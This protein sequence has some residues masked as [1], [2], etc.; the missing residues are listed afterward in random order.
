VSLKLKNKLCSGLVSF[1]HKPETKN[2]TM[3][4]VHVSFL[5]KLET[6]NEIVLDVSISFLHEL[7]TKSETVIGM[8]PIYDFL[9][10]VMSKVGILSD[11][12]RQGF[13]QHNVHRFLLFP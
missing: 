10:N 5:H 9:P 3:L 6:E 13:S 4:M 8:I 11:T 12:H 2:K 7:K 1:L